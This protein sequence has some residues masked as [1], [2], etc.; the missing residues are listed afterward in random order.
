V[1]PL[2]PARHQ[3]HVQQ[4]FNTYLGEA[5]AALAA[6]AQDTDDVDAAAATLGL[7]TAALE[8][9]PRAE[10]ALELRARAPHAQTLP[11]RLHSWLEIDEVR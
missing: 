4:V 3:V 1:A 9:S 5:R 6:A 7:V 2:R 10:A 8:M 11:R